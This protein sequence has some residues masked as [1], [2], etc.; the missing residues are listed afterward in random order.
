MATN[1]GGGLNFTV[2]ELILPFVPY[3]TAEHW[4]VATENEEV[5]RKFSENFTTLTFYFLIQISLVLS[6]MIDLY[7]SM[8]VKRRKE[9]DSDNV[10]NV[11]YLILKNM[12]NDDNTVRLQ[13]LRILRLIVEDHAQTLADVCN[14]FFTACHVS[15][16]AFAHA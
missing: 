1:D 3:S 6:E 5:Q 2:D 13:G 16:I 12:M 9:V 11:V 8:E 7:S 14:F 15:S 10:H 4:L